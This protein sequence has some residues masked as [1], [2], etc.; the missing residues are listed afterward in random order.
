[1]GS[2]WKVIPVEKS[3]E[4]QFLS[5]LDRDRI[6]H[7]FTIYDLK[8]MRDKTRVWAAFKDHEICGYLFEF[9]NRI[10]HT[11]GTV[12]SV[13]KLLHCIELDE[14]VLIIEP[15]HLAVVKEFFEPVEPTDA[16]SKGKITKYL[17]M[18]TGA[19]TFNP[20]IRHR[21]KRLRTEDVNGVLEHL[22]EEWEKRVKDAIHRGIAF[23]A[24][25]GDLLASV[26]TVPETIDNIAFIRGV[27]TAPSRRSRGLSTSVVSALVKEII[28][29][30]KEA[31]LWVAEDN[32]PAKRLYEKIGFQKTE[33][34][35]LGFK[36]RR[37]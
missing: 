27:Y 12:E 19:N 26:A 9:D 22:G 18:K 14:P 34:I 3:N 17:V 37:L 28:N 2:E 15:D 35:I 25:E 23:G 21:V 4:K 24:Y 5:F 33:H 36:A 31:V 32:L 30:G 1:M 7:V 11:H 8:Y 29:L 13:T 20:I 16:S 6:S 10:V